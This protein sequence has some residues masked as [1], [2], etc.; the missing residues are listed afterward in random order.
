MDD[1]DIVFVTTTLFSDCLD[2]QR[3]IIKNM[4]PGSEHILIDGTDIIKWPN[5]M[6]YWI[7]E[8]KDRSEK[9]FILL[10][11]DCFL[12]NKSEILRT[13]SLLD[14]YDFMG[15]P[16]GYHPLRKCNP[17]VL[18]TF[19]LFGKVESLREIKYDMSNL[20]YK[21]GHKNGDFGWSVIGD[22][23]YKSLYKDNFN[24]PHKIMGSGSF[25]GGNEPYYF[26][27][28]HLLDIGMKFGY[29]YPH[30]D[31]ENISTNPKIDENS[32]EMAIHIW[33]S[34]NMKKDD[35]LIGLTTKERFN[36]F[37]NLNI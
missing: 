11:E 3:K 1:K 20:R 26:L 8:I 36:R 12:T 16:D 15:C 6:F 13:L 7:N 4:F 31:S 28:W 27:F 29:L 5:L 18:N 34:R 17:I 10:D 25:T 30:Y 23:K 32:P 9:Y 35:K 37:L 24:Y 2:I 21:L 33:E 22:I 14:T 19:L